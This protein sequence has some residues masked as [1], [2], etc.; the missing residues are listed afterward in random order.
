[1]K[2]VRGIKND[3]LEASDEPPYFIRAKSLTND[4]SDL[5]LI[6]PIQYPLFEADYKA[7][8]IIPNTI[9]SKIKREKKTAPPKTRIQPIRKT[10]EKPIPQP[11]QIKAKAKKATAKVVSSKKS[12]STKAKKNRRKKKNINNSESSDE[13]SSS[14]E[15][16]SKPKHIDR[17]ISSPRKRPIISNDHL[18][19]EKKHK[20]SEELFQDGQNFLFREIQSLQNYQFDV[21]NTLIRNS[22]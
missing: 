14:S 1:M 4:M 2:K 11:Q 21:V 9:I 6:N 18:S 8:L 10:E 19:P 3:L 17:V 15:T 12:T 7:E 20:M 5:K 22:S 13:S 16:E